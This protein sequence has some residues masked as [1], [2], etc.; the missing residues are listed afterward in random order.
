MLD[1]PSV[2]RTISKTASGITSA[3]LD[4]RGPVSS[5]AI[6][7]GAG[8]RHEAVSAPGVAHLLKNTLVRVSRGVAMIVI[9]IMIDGMNEVQ[10]LIDM[11]NCSHSHILHY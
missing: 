4:D 8:S 2:V 9:V 10:M 6:V 1:A 5:L 11:I 7:I 3:A